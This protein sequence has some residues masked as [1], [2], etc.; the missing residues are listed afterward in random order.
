MNCYVLCVVGLFCGC[1]AEAGGVAVPQ[2]K[3]AIAEG[4]TL[5]SLQLDLGKAQGQANKLVIVENIASLDN[6][7]SKKFLFDYFQHLP[8]A[9]LTTD[10][11]SDHYKVAVF[12]IVLSMLDGKERESFLVDVL[13]REMKDLR[14][15]GVQYHAAE[16]YPCTLW[17]KTL[18]SLES[19]GL[20]SDVRGKLSAIGDDVGIPET[21]RSTFKACVIRQ[22]FGTNSSETV[23]KIRDMLDKYPVRP[24]SI[25]P[26]DIFNDKERRIAYGKSEE[27]KNKLASFGQWRASGALVTYE[28]YERVL[29][30]CGITAIEQIVAFLGRDDVSNER[31]DCLA[32][33]AASLLAKHDKWSTQERV[34]LSKLVDQLERY[35]DQMEDKGAF[36]Y[37][38][39]AI[40]GLAVYYEKMG[41]LDHHKFTWVAD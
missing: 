9:E 30:S 26:W 2:E 12:D 11:N 1:Y 22:E 40:T 27:Y 17:Q 5:E 7:D 31:R 6:A 41:I 35:V 21:V 3:A 28:T 8:P 16:M 38:S 13:T 33:V 15:A 29:L 4:K 39:Y 32:M 23:L 20:S 18:R 34:I 24:M 37:R 10:P 36:S 25:I 19:Y 14:E